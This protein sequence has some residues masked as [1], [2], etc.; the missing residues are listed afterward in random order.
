[1]FGTVECLETLLGRLGRLPVDQAARK[2]DFNIDWR[3][4]IVEGLSLDASIG[5]SGRII[6][7]RNNLVAIPARTLV[8]VGGR[9]AF[10]LGASP[11]SFRL[12]V[13]NIFN[14]YG[15]DLR[16]AGSYDLIDGR[17]ASARLTVD[18]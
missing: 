17:V 3:P 2:V 14:T 18:F 9:Y 7:T 11:A 16:G 13:S 8:D 10:K 5:H 12:S 6:A 15:F 4:P 1:M